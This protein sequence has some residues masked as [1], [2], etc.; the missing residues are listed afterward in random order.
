MQYYVSYSWNPTGYQGYTALAKKASVEWA[1][2]HWSVNCQFI[3]NPDFPSP[4]ILTRSP[5]NTPGCDRERN[6]ADRRRGSSLL[7]GHYAASG[8]CEYWFATFS[9]LIDL[10]SRNWFYRAALYVRALYIP[11]YH[12]SAVCPFVYPS[13]SWAVAIVA[14]TAG[15]I[16]MFFAL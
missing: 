13:H 11:H 7:D 8:T 16:E 1:S 15:R 5:Y 9:L 12:G 4:I 10:L 14:K 3:L 2:R 6:Q